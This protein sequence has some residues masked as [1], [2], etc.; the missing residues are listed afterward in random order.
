MN[1]TAG[2]KTTPF[3]LWL[4]EIWLQNCDE[5]DLVHEPRYSQSEYFQMYKYWLKR[6]YKYQRSRNV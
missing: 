4:H 3:R 2:N 6:E 1:T 5:H